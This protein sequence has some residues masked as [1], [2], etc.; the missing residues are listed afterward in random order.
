MHW[1]VC[2]QLSEIIPEDFQAE[3]SKLGDR[4]WRLNNLYKIKNEAGEI[5]PFRFNWAQE[6]FYRNIWYFN[7]ILKARQLG[8]STAIAIYALDACLWNDNYRCGII[9]ASLPDAKKKLEK[10]RFAYNNLPEFLKIMNPLSKDGAEEMEFANGSGIVCGTS[11]RGDT[12][13]LLHVS[14]YGKIA[15]RYPDKAKEI[16]TGALNAVHAGQQIFVESTAEGQQGEFFDLVENARKL[17]DS[18]AHLTQLD[19]RFHFYPWWRHP[20]YK[21]GE[22]D[23]KNTSIDLEMQQYF[24]SLAA[25]GIDLSPGQKAWY[26]KKKATQGE[27]MKREFPSTPE[28]AFESSLEG[29]FYTKQMQEVRKRKQIGFFPHEPSKPVYTFW[30]IG[31]NDEMS[32]WF[33][34]HIG[35]EYRFIRYYENSGEG[36]AHYANV[37]QSTGYVFGRH[38]WPHDGN[39]RIL[40]AQVTTGKQAAM[41][42]GIR[43]IE[44]VPR[45][46]DVMADI[47]TYCRPVLPR[48]F[49][50]E[51]GCSEGIK[52]LDSYRKEWDDRLGLWK[53][54]PLHD[55]ASNCADAFRTFAVGYKGRS[56]E[57]VDYSAR[58]SVAVADYDEF[59]F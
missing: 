34:Q 36:F 30:D 25:K 7:A 8:F 11:H 2:L 3:I 48:C 12:L 53:D 46:N 58:P 37:L 27:L 45:T 31:L 38:Y 32:I 56:A 9:D 23:I 20:N 4:H 42:I 33:M 10:A 52:Y 29:A 49:F 24:A 26:I 51:A 19:P 54:K 55:R 40:G 44:V 16:K 1:K 15:A 5:I 47:N 57:F 43:P 39:K 6:D 28:E 17:S 41:E 22:I 21:L 14:E 18:G 50:D 59:K 13:Q 35:H